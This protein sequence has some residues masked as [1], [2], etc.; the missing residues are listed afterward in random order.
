M[1]NVYGPYQM[2][3]ITPLPGAVWL[4]GSGLAGLGLWRGRKLFR[5]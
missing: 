1:S 3:V 5:A 4:L 2:A